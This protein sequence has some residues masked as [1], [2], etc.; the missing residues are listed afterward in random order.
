LAIVKINPR[1]L[2]G[3]WDVGY[4][5]D[6]HTVSS[7]FLGNNERGHAEFETTRSE[8]GELLYRLKYR[9]DKTAIQPLAD[10]VADFLRDKWVLPID[11]IIPAAPSISRSVQPVRVVAE[12]LAD[13]IGI[14]V[15]KTCLKKIKQTPQL[16]DIIGY[17]ERREILADAFDVHTKTTAGKNILLFDDVFGSGATVWHITETLKQKGEAEAVYLLTLTTK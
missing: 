2:Y 1:R 16:K 12:V 3:P 4:A 8:V 10:T 13:R 5:L 14:P 15:S 11:L 9:H 7:L 6:K 17:D